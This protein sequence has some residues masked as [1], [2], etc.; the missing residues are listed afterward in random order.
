MFYG[1]FEVHVLWT[2][3]QRFEIID[4]VYD[5]CT[6]CLNKRIVYSTN[7]I[8]NLVYIDVIEIAWWNTQ[9]NMQILRPKSNT[10]IDKIL[11]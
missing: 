6:F 7:R 11:W 4:S 2:F 1:N 5:I 3:L 9:D 10:C 8:E